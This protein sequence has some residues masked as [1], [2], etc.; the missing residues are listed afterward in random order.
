MYKSSRVC[1]HDMRTGTCARCIVCTRLGGSA[2]RVQGDCNGNRSSADRLSGRFVILLHRTSFGKR[3]FFGQYTN[4]DDDFPLFF[5]TWNE[6]FVFTK[7][8]VGLTGDNR[9]LA[10]AARVFSYEKLLPLFTEETFL[11]G[12]ESRTT[13]ETVKSRLPG[14][15][16]PGKCWRGHNTKTVMKRGDGQSRTLFSCD[17]VEAIV[18]YA[19]WNDTNTDDVVG[20]Q[21]N[22]SFEY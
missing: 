17:H 19:V 4:G 16:A 1:F 8:S 22:E 11:F 5:L 12:Y 14:T 10:A 3:R 9:S 18:L 20:V 21:F 13:L 2:D 6:I 7:T 15:G